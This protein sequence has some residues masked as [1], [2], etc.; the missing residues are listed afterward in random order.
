L[1]R[2]AREVAQARYDLRGICLP[3]MVS[4]VEGFAP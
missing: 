2:A 1:R 4:F 3:R